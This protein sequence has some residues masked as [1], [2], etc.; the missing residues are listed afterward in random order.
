MGKND[1][2]RRFL[3]LLAGPVRRRTPRRSERATRNSSSV[4]CGSS[5]PGFG[6]DGWPRCRSG[7]AGVAHRA[8]RD[9]GQFGSGL[10]HA[11]REGKEDREPRPRERAAL[12]CLPGELSPDFRT[13]AI[14]GGAQHLTDGLSVPLPLR[15]HLEP[16]LGIDGEGTREKLIDVVGQSPVP[17]IV[18][19]GQ[20]F[21]DPVP[22]L[23]PTCTC[24]LVTRGPFVS[25]PGQCHAP[26]AVAQSASKSARR[27]GDVL[28]P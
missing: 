15:S 26:S 28:H 8:V 3:S 7:P 10:V 5:R 24:G 27:V 21:G 4:A 23:S 25:A 12:G 19:S 20:A 11:Q 16:A 9:E 22:C 6:R 13:F 17:G 2:V 1:R 18:R 14:L